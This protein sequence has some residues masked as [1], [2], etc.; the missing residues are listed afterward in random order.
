MNRKQ[1]RSKWKILII[2]FC[3]IFITS[4][5]GFTFYHE[6]VHGAIYNQYGV[7]Y[8]KGFMFDKETY[9]LPTFYVQAIDSSFMMCNEVCGSLQTENEIISYNMHALSYT[10]WSICLIWLLVTFIKDH[11]NI[12][13]EIQ[14]EPGNTTT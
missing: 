11:E 10:L 1:L 14:D 7:N 5:L 9:Y 13:E 6:E 8:T 12:K 2:F 3:M 4:E